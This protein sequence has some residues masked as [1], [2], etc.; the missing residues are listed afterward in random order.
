M[1]GEAVAFA[2]GGNSRMLRAQNWASLCSQYK[3]PGA[4]PTKA[5]VSMHGMVVL[6]L[7]RRGRF[8]LPCL[9]AAHTEVQPQYG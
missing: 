3:G 9:T 6:K 7:Q 4:P 8:V 1:I 5:R 2:L